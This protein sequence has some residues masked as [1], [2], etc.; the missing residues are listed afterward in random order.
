METIKMILEHSK[1]FGVL[2][3]ALGLLLK[4]IFKFIE[5]QTKKKNG[6]WVD[7][8]GISKKVEDLHRWHCAGVEDGMNIKFISQSFGNSFDRMT[9]VLESQKEILKNLVEYRSADHEILLKINTK[10]EKA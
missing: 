3:I 4:E 9:K 1:D 6:T 2:L 5:S 7:V 8:A 10:I